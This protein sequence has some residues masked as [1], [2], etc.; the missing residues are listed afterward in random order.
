[1]SYNLSAIVGCFDS[2]DGGP[3]DV[4][5]NR[6]PQACCEQRTFCS[7]QKMKISVWMEDRSYTLNHIH[8]AP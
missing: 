3:G 2:E 5:P 8:S 1:M 4:K 7:S 6:K